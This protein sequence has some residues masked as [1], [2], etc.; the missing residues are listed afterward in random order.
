[1][2][3]ATGLLI[4]LGFGTTLALGLFGVSSLREGERRAARWFFGLAVLCA[5]CFSLCTFLP[6]PLQWTV[7]GIAAVVGALLGRVR[8]DT[9]SSLWVASALILAIPAVFIVLFA[10]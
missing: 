3:A 10:T 7:L 2:D 5:L 9:N 6:D 4:V 8:G 1:M